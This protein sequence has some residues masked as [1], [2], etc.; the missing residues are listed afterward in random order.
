MCLLNHFSRV[1]LFATL[2]T[3]AHQAPLSMG[4][5]QARIL[6]WVAMPSSRKSAPKDRTRVSCGNC[7]ADGFFTAEPQ[8]KPTDDVTEIHKAQTVDP[9]AQMS[10]FWKGQERLDCHIKVFKIT[11]LH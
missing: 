5:F 7:I 8:G 11:E 10:S 1:R 9:R 6:E 2:W 4:N 3:V